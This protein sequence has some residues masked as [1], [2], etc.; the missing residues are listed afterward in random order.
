MNHLPTLKLTFCLLITLCCISQPSSAQGQ[1]GDSQRF[2]VVAQMGGPVNDSVSMPDDSILAS[3]GSSLVRIS[4]TF[5]PLEVIARTDLERGMILALIAAPPYVLALSEEGLLVLPHEGEGIPHPITFL[6][7]GGQS[8]A[9]QGD[10]IAVASHQSGLRLIRLGVSG[11]LTELSRI[12]LNA[13]GGEIAAALD[14]TLSPDQQ[15]AYIATGDQGVQIVDIRDSAAP[16]PF[17]ALPGVLP[18]EAVTM[19]GGRLAGGSAGEVGVADTAPG[20]GGVGLY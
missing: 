16:I 6:A 5:G 11:T 2:E 10:L 8:M 9:V 7:G 19:S 17:G 12:V 20:A 3:E 14:V 4:N 1:E 13:P 18:A 15:F